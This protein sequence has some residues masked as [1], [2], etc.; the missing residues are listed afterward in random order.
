M[1][2][3]REIRPVEVEVVTHLYLELCR[4]LSGRDNDWGF[5]TVSPSTGGRRR[6]PDGSGRRGT[7]DSA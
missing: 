2:T 6:V 5:P 3:I 7:T 4:S 1:T